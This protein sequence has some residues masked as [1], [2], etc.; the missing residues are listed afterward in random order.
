MNEMKGIYD[1]DGKWSEKEED[2]G[3]IA[4]SYFNDLLS[5]NRPNRDDIM[6]VVNAID[7]KISDEGKKILD[8][9]FTKRE[10]EQAIKGMN[11][12][13]ASGPDGAHVM[14]YQKYWDILGE[15]TTRTCLGILN[16]KESMDP[17]NGTHIVLIP[18]LK[19]PKKM[20]DF[21]PISMCNVI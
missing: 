1:S 9:P 11:L 14:L 8:S 17:I 21:R 3:R 6:E 20:K 13:K 7:S 10:I 5:S 19:D 18:K 12:S 16:N 2:I 15:D 4:T